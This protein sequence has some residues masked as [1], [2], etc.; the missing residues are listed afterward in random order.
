MWKSLLNGTRPHE[1][2]FGGSGSVFRQ[3][4]YDTLVF[5]WSHHA[6]ARRQGV[7]SVSA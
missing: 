3:L 2:F 7:L 4:H 5:A 6:T 1:L